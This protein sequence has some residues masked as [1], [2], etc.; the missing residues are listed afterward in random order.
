MSSDI[1]QK[2]R[3]TVFT[4]FNSEIRPW[5][6]YTTSIYH[7]PSLT[8]DISYLPIASGFNAHANTL[9]IEASGSDINFYTSNNFTTNFNN[10]VSFKDSISIPGELN[11]PGSMNVT[12]DIYSDGAANFTTLRFGNAGA[13]NTLP[14]GRGVSGQFLSTNGDGRI[15]WVNIS[16]DTKP[17]VPGIIQAEKEVIVDEFRDISGFRNI[18]MDGKFESKNYIFDIDGNVSGLQTVGCGD[19]SSVGIIECANIKTDGTLTGPATFII[20]PAAQ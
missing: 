20:D 13:E 7:D 9:N 6:L 17:S 5:R 1:I 15:D 18:T 8:T 3:D 10:A 16:G 4:E 14:Y 19:I 2:E 12:G 11:V